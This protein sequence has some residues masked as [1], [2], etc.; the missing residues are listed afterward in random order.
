MPTATIRKLLSGRRI[1]SLN[2][3]DGFRARFIFGAFMPKSSLRQTVLARRKALPAREAEAAGLLVQQTFTGTREFAEARAVAL[4]APIHNEV[5]TADVA[6]KALSA[7]KIVLFP[8]VCPAGIEF[9]RISDPAAL[10]K[11]AFGIPEPDANC[12]VHSP[13]EADL[14]VVPGVVFD[15]QGRRIG[16]G[17]GYYDRALHLLEGSGRLVGFCYDF[18][19]VEE[20]PGEPHDVRMDLIITERRVIRPGD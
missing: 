12:P 16:Y 11:G 19:L 7:A 18:Q 5:E 9:R 10:C 13:G 14:I 20:I 17:K 3:T 6:R 2:E 1:F 15:V 8:V 4:Y